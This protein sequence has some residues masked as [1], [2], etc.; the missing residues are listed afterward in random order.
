VIAGG[1]TLDVLDWKMTKKNRLAEV[2]HSG[3]GGNAQY[4]KTVNEYSGSVTANW[5]STAMPE[6][7]IDVGTTVTLQ[8]YMGDSNKFYSISALIETLEPSV[9]NQQGHVTYS[10]TWKGTGAM[11]NPA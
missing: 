1:V 5:D 7:V 3:S 10:F 8:L 9:P 2:T 11:T 4:L 6:A